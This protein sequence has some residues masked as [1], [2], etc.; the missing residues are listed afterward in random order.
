MNPILSISLPIILAYLIGGIPTGFIFVKLIR[1]QDIRKQ[2]SGNIGATNT[3]RVLGP[4]LAVIVLLIDIGK[5]VG[6]VILGTFLYAK[7]GINNTALFLSLVGIATILGHIYS[8]FLGFRGGKGVATAAGVFFMLTPIP[9]LIAFAAF[10]L[11]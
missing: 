5:G 2:G 6:A 8:V 7:F 11:L 10:I 1:K 4:G 9:L 3:M